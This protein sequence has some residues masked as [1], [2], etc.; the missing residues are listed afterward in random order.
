MSP[1]ARPLMPLPLARVASNWAYAICPYLVRI[2][3]PAQY[4]AHATW[5]RRATS[6][7]NYQPLLFDFDVAS[8]AFRFHFLPRRIKLH[9][10][11]R[12]RELAESEVSL[13]DCAG[14]VAVGRLAADVHHLLK[15]QQ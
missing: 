14:V 12:R 10:H 7:E 2:A 5:I 3:T 8:H 1:L 4:A 15:P 13:R 9:A 11:I 6:H